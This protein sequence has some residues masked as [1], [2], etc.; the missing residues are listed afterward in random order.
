MID[1]IIHLFGTLNYFT[2]FALLLFQ[3][4]FPPLPTEVAVPFCGYAAARGDLNVWGVAA[5]A[6]LG[7]LVGQL[8]WYV[9]GWYFGGAR[10]KGL[11]AR[12]GRW[13]TVTPGEVELVLN[14][15]YRFGAVSVFFGA[16]IPAIRAVISL[17]AGIARVRFGTYLPFVAAGTAIWMTILSYAGYRLGQNYELVAR[18]VAPGTKAVGALVVV[19]YLARLALSFRKPRT[20]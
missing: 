20:S 9:A 5:A 13:L 3:G 6:T 4:L 7:A 2:V 16:M 12:Y 14:W 1:H 10:V 18:Y 15:F 17:P 8:P 11:A 19:A